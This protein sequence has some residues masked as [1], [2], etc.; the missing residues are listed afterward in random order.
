MALTDKRNPN[1]TRTTVVM[2][3]TRWQDTLEEAGVTR[4]N[5]D[6]SNNAPACTCTINEYG[7]LMAALVG[8]VGLNDMLLIASFTEIYPGHSSNG[9]QVQHY[10][11]FPGL[12]LL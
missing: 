5:F 6:G 10:F 1:D 7:R 12:E 3:M 8:S 11:T 2:R 9:V 4:Y